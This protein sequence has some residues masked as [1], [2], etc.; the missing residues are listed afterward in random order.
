MLKRIVMKRVFYISHKDGVGL[1]QDQGFIGRR[2]KDDQFLGGYEGRQRSPTKNFNK[3]SNG[4][5]ISSEIIIMIKSE[6]FYGD[7]NAILK[8]AH[9]KL[10][11]NYI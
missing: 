8:F 7:F 6:L 3:I 4:S 10:F 11:E 9:F 5:K 2:Q 1:I